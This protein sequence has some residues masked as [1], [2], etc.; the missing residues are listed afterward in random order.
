MGISRRG[1]RSG[2]AVFGWRRGRAPESP[3]ARDFLALLL[4]KEANLPIDPVVAR[5]NMGQPPAHFVHAV[6]QKIAPFPGQVRQ[7]RPAQDVQFRPQFLQE[8]KVKVFDLFGAGVGPQGLAQDLGQG[9]E[10]LERPG[11]RRLPAGF[12]VRQL[13]DPVHHSISQRLVAVGA[14]PPPGR[15][16]F[17]GGA[18][19]AGPVA[20]QMVFPFLGKKLDGP[21]ES[22]LGAHRPGQVREGG[23]HLKDIG[24][25]GQFCR[26]MGVGVGDQKI[27]VQRTHPP[28]HG[29]VGG[30]PGLQSIDPLRMLLKTLFQGIEAAFGPQHRKPGGPD[31]GGDD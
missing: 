1:G 29:R 21:P 4:G 30:Q 14:Y 20:V 22:F 10:R 15:G 8:A 26:G 19:V 7:G 6:S 24:L 16:L 11:F 23:G 12:P 27:P 17:R 9:N 28:V 2:R 3:L 31:V 5:G 18:Q 13:Q 25:P